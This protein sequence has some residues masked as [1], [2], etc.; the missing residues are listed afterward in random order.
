VRVSGF[1]EWSGLDS[2]FLGLALELAWATRTFN[3]LARTT[4]SSDAG[5]LFR[6]PQVIPELRIHPPKENKNADLSRNP[7]IGSDTQR[8]RSAV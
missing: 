2:F 8:R 1:I 3:S 6:T 7:T 5:G 4:T